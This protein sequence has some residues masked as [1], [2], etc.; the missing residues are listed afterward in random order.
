M[1]V[2]LAGSSSSAMHGALVPIGYLA[3]SGSSSN[4]S[5][6]NIPQIYQD[7]RL[8]IF[9]RG[10]YAATTD[11]L[12]LNTQVGTTSYTTLH[13]IG[14]GSTVT[15]TR[16]ANL[17]TTLRSSIAGANATS[18]IFSSVTIDILNY[19]N[20][21]IYKTILARTATDLNGSGNT[22]ITVG[23]ISSTEAVTTLTASLQLGSLLTS[24]STAT[25]Y[26]VRTVGQ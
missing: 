14:N 18:G 12:G 6:S 16:E 13:L 9:A 2:S 22:E 23:V 5:F 24:G 1:P 17:Y 19:A 20:T 25:L 26:G 15:A 7:L 3:A 11:L 21:T 8:V 4:L 10:N